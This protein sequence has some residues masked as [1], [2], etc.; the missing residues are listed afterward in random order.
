MSRPPS[1]L[2]L[3]AI[4]AAAAGAPAPHGLRAGADQ[5]CSPWRHR[6]IH[7]DSRA[8]LG[9]GQDMAAPPEKSRKDVPVRDWIPHPPAD[10]SDFLDGPP[11]TYATPEQMAEYERTGK[12]IGMDE[13]GDPGEPTAEGEPQSGGEPTVEGAHETPRMGEPATGVEPPAGGAPPK[14]GD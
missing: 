3:H 11:P 12:K 2:G 8:N 4:T 9:E 1:W 13:P 6:R 14:G 10:P 5:E 7:P